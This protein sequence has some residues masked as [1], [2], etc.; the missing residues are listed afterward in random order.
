MKNNTH[1]KSIVPEVIFSEPA[2]YVKNVF[3]TSSL[4]GFSGLIKS[5]NP[6]ESAAKTI[7]IVCHYRQ[8][9][10]VLE[11]EQ[12]RIKK[13]AELEHKKIDAT[14]QIGVKLLEERRQ[15]ISA[16]LEAVT[17]DLDQIHLEKTAI[18][19]SIHN[20]TRNLGNPDLSVEEKNY[21]HTII[22]VLTE[23]LTEMGR[24]GHERLSLIAANTQKALEAVPEPLLIKQ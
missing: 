22:S 14:Y 23:A 21:S 4:S 13:E 20:L 6:F 24:Q 3:P 11:T 19:D 8:Q 2:G 7:A 17:K 16:C 9:I 5:L 15:S 18:I 10:K 12:L 1:S